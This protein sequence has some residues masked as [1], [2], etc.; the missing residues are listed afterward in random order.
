MR[1]RYLRELYEE[2]VAKIK[3]TL[4]YC[5]IGVDVIVGFPGENK[6][7]FLETYKFL[8]ELD[9]SYLHVFT[10]S[11]RENTPAA[12]MAGS[13][14]LRE[15]QERSK[16]LHNLS[17]KKRRA[18]YQS[19]L[20]RN[21]TVLFENDIEDGFM[22]G[23]TENYVRVKAKYDPILVNEIKQVKINSVTS[24]GVCDV[25]EVSLELALRLN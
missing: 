14:S 19:N 22:H 7:D 15:R 13:V 21:L 11:E 18:F 2:R 17:E 6:E 3:S 8:N 10:Y 9:I 25:E 4:P 23:Y 16:Q 24:N 20:N 12:T 1:R 5:C